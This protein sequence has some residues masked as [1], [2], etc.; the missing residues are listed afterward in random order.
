MAEVTDTNKNGLIAAIGIV[1][2][3]SL[4]FFARWSLAPGHWLDE[5]R[6]PILT[7][8]M[9]IAILG[10][11]LYLALRLESGSRTYSWAVGLLLSGI[12][13]IFFAFLWAVRAWEAFA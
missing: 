11:S 4:N 13:V 3:F 5:H 9:G 2:G 7:L 6:G 1:L 8:T 12:S 10:V